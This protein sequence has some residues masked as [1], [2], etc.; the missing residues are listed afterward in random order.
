[1]ARA[2]IPTIILGPAPDVTTPTYPGTSYALLQTGTYFDFGNCSQFTVFC[3][4][5]QAPTGTG[6]QLDV[7]I[8]HSPDMTNWATLDD[9][10][11]ITAAGT[12]FLSIPANATADPQ[13]FAPFIRIMG[14]YAN[15]DNVFTFT[16]QATKTE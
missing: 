6:P 16:L 11:A 4:V 15:T 12:T 13:T 1:M 8:E 9:M 14:K 7:R 5:H 2:R 10:A 3:T